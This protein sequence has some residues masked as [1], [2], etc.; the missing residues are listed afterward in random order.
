M[1]PKRLPAFA[2]NPLH[3]RPGR[4]IASAPCRRSSGASDSANSAA[5]RPHG[6]PLDHR[7]QMDDDA[8]LSA[9]PETI[10]HGLVA[11][12]NRLSIPAG[13]PPGGSVYCGL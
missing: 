8:D 1:R 4:D 6:D 2:L 3:L 12:I 11:T 10:R 5:F 7:R 13:I 9:L